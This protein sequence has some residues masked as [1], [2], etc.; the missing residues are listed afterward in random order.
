MCVYF[1]AVSGIV[2]RISR[3]AYTIFELL[4]Y[5]YRHFSDVVE[6]DLVVEIVPIYPTWFEMLLSDVV[7]IRR[8]SLASVVE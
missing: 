1:K 8:L 7:G 3:Q 5:K 4:C 2:F 6:I